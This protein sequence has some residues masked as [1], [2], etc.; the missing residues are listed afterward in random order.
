[1]TVKR[2]EHIFQA[3][4]RHEQEEESGEDAEWSGS[5]GTGIVPVRAEDRAWKGR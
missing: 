3:E 1:M 2:R 4:E 5:A